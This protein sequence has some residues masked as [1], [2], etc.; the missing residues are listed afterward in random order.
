MSS[1]W[2]N[3]LSRLENEIPSSDFSTWVRPLQAE[4][5]NH[6]IRLLAPNR[7][8]LDWVTQHYF[9]KFEEAINE[10]SN[11][12]LRLSLEIG[13]KAANKPVSKP[14]K[15]TTAIRPMV[16]PIP[17]AFVFAKLNTFSILMDIIHLEH[18]YL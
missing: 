1:T 13:S 8:V 12:S 11:G 4:E 10:F 7:F 17:M 5:N 3:C 18:L 2:N 9:T 14:I 15:K 16:K 6:Q